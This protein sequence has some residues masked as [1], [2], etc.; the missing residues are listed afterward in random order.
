MHKT[1]ADRQA[2][3]IARNEARRAR[4]P[5][6]QLA[7]IRQRPGKSKRETARL[8]DTMQ[9]FTDYVEAC[10]VAHLYID[11]TPDHRES[12]EHAWW[13]PEEA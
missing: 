2:E 7:L 1:R 4:T 8:L 5:V 6:Q 3:A 12:S 11:R 10:G 9:R 13:Y